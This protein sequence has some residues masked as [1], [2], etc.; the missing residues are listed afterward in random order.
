MNTQLGLHTGS[1]PV[2]GRE[3]QVEFKDLLSGVPGEASQK[4]RASENFDT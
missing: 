1:A 3:R 4:D 2:G